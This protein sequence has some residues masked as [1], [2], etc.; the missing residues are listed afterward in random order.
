MSKGI[1][2]RRFQRLEIPLEVS[3]E[4]VAAEEVLQKLHPRKMKS[5][6]ISSEGIC[7]ETRHIEVDGINLLSGPPGARENRVRLEI[8][9][10]PGEP[11]FSA[12]GEVCWYD[13]SRD[14]PEFM[15]QVGIEFIE[16]ESNGKTQLVRFLK[17]KK[18]H[19]GFM[20]KLFG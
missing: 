2:K 10:I 5:C 6:N 13:V 16:I 9:L 15:Y 7:L 8:E 11:L 4:I 1:E 12:I 18:N 17:S 20:S 19:K 14:T 3:L